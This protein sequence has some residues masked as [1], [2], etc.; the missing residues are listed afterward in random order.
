MRSH[1][2]SYRRHLWPWRL[3]R[4]SCRVGDRHGAD[5]SHGRRWRAKSSTNRAKPSG[6]FCLADADDDAVAKDADHHQY[7]GCRR[8]TDRNSQIGVHCS[9]AF[10]CE[11]VWPD[12]ALD[13]VDLTD[14][15]AAAAVAAGN[16]AGGPA[17]EDLVGL[18][19]ADAAFVSAFA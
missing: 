14:D 4:N 2:D 1:W 18:D 13:V 15:Y 9:F 3:K 7:H 6:F 10:A 12:G 17:S 11:T 5:C 8:E 16:Q 19:N